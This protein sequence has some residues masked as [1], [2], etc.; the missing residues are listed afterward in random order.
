M[1]N[2]FFITI[3]KIIFRCSIFNNIFHINH[4]FNSVVIYFLKEI[5][6]P[7]YCFYFILKLKFI[8]KDNIA[9]LASPIKPK[10]R[11]TP[12]QKKSS[13]FNE[14]YWLLGN[15]FLRGKAEKNIFLSI[16]K[17]ALLLLRPKSIGSYMQSAR[18]IIPL[19]F[20][21]CILS[22]YYHEYYEQPNKRIITVIYQIVR[23]L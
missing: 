3:F 10:T 23:V 20:H 17:A 15:T 8:A 1:N 7:F 14:I 16:K 12:M 18:Q 21:N 4:I 13:S 6:F 11:K 2:D 9:F 22:L 5:M 19:S